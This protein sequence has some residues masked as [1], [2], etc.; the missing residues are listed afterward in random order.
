MKKKQDALILQGGGALGAY[1]VGVIERL[2][3]HPGFQPEVITGVSIGA[4]NAAALAG[5]PQSPMSN[6]K[7][8]WEE[9]TVDAPL[10]VP[11]MLAPYMSVFG[12]QGFYRMRTDLA[13][14]PFWTSFYDTSPLRAVLEKYIDFE[15]LNKS[16]VKVAVT[17]ANVRTGKV[18]VFDNHSSRKLLPEH[19]LASGSLPPGF[20]M[21]RVGEEW[22]WDGGLFDNTPL[23][24]AIERLDSDPEVQKRLFV[25][26]LFPGE[27][28]L[29]Q[30]MNEVFDR[31]LEIVFAGKMSQDVKTA[32]RVN[33]YIGLVHRIDEL[34]AGA[35]D[36]DAAAEIRDLP[37][38]KRL[39][40]YKALQQIVCIENKDPEIVTGPFDFSRKRIE[41]RMEAGYRDA[42]EALEAVE[43]KE[44]VGGE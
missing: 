40:Q 11:E 7:A 41:Q 30:N 26:K 9:F 2:M 23:L 3:E 18:D 36:P 10:L 31:I 42:D 17:A 44:A 33:E 4:I 22:Y 34:L 19:L 29:P 21:T 13:V 24:P 28:P 1:E 37:G 20:P 5:A 16:K 15:A 38:Y 12:N 6:L 27:G 14:M 35:E 25:V 32:E 43:K 8:M 39:Q